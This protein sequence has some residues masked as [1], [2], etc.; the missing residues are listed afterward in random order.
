MADVWAVASYYRGSFSLCLAGSAI[1]VVVPGGSMF[2]LDPGTIH[3]YWNLLVPD[4]L[5]AHWKYR[6]LHS[7]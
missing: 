2:H 1:R 4:V 7:F 6:K 5:D 3:P